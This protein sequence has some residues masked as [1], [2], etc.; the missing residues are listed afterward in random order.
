MEVAGLL[1][2]MG[3][4]P[5]PMEV[6]GLPITSGR[7]PGPMEVAGLLVNPLDHLLA[8]IMSLL[9]EIPLGLVAPL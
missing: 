1:I 9:V 7:T 8:T 5:D 6:A 2:L 4:A 3:R